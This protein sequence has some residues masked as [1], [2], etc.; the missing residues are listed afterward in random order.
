LLFRIPFPKS[1]KAGA[2]CENFRRKSE[3]LRSVYHKTGFYGTI[4]RNKAARRVAA[5]A[6]PERPAKFCQE[7]KAK[8]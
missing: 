5:K 8:K 3:L 2:F 1:Q 4:N 6:S 7:G